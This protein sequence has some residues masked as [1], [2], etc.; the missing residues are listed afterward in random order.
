MTT[1][2]LITTFNRTPL[3]QVSLER[4]CSLTLPDDVLIVDDGGSDGCR[5][6]CDEFAGRLP[7]RYIYNHNPGEA[8]C[9]HARNVGIRNTDLDIIVTSEP[10]AIFETDVI[11]QMLRLHARESEHVISAGTIHH[12]QPN[13][14]E[15]TI[16]GWVAPFVALY[17]RSWLFDI[18]GWDEGF[19]SVW[20]WEDV[21][22]LSRLRALGHGQV[23]S[24]E[25][26]VTHQWHPPRHCDQGPNEGRFLAKDLQNSTEH[27]V[28][29]QG[30]DWGCIRTS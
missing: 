10:E 27:I 28:A 25:I 15:E 4:L 24:P 29:N 20:G 21:D 8:I 22:L 3:L 16:V 17:V 30:R 9:S 1:T 11:G 5:E 23:I 19:E 7:I 2:L 18:G 13:G 6:L 12:R 14:T 26:Q